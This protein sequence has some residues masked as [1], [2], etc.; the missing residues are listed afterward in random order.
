VLMWKLA[1]FNL[2][3]IASTVQLLDMSLGIASNP[4]A[5]P[6]GRT[7]FRATPIKTYFYK[8]AAGTDWKCVMLEQLCICRHKLC[9]KLTSSMSS[10]TD[11]HDKTMC[12]V[13]GTR[14]TMYW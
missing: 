11:P 1:Y 4:L 12:T 7:G 2:L 10:Y 3:D 13:I 5:L 8:W 14:K 6:D 9:M